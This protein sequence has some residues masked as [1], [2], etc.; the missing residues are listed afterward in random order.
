MVVDAVAAEL[1]VV[2]GC[3]KNPRRRM[4]QNLRRLY[5]AAAAR[6]CT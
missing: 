2:V 3:P 6:K 4:E 1:D 5:T